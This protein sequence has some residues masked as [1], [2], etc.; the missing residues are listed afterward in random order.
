[1][2]ADSY[3]EALTAWAKVKFP[4]FA[5]ITGDVVTLRHIE[6]SI[7]YGCSTCG[8]G[9]E[10]SHYV[11]EVAGRQLD[12]YETYQIPGLLAEI[13]AVAQGLDIETD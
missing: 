7:G 10:D 3:D 12:R 5:W 11:V 9:D 1:M 8:Y 2:D 13:I 6:A 4:H